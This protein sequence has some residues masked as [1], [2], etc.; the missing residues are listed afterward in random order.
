MALTQRL[1]RALRAHPRA[2][3]FV[4]A[5][6]P[7]TH[8]TEQH[9]QCWM[10]QLVNKAQRRVALA[11]DGH[12]DYPVRMQGKSESLV[13]SV[14]LVF[15]VRLVVSANIS[16][17]IVA[18]SAGC[19]PPCEE[20]TEVRSVREES[21]TEVGLHGVFAESTPGKSIAV[22]DNGTIL[23][24][25]EDG[26]WTVGVSGTSVTL[27]AVAG[28]GVDAVA[29]G[30]GGTIVQTSDAG[31]TW[32]VVASGTTTDLHAVAFGPSGSTVI[33]V[34]A[35]GA[36]HSHDNGKTW[37]ITKLPENIQPLRA[38]G[39]FNRASSTNVDF[40]AAGDN[41]EVLLSEDLGGNWTRL[42]VGTRADLR[43][44]GLSA[45]PGATGATFMVA[46]AAGIARKMLDEHGKSW[47]PH[48]LALTADIVHISSDYQWQLAVDGSVVLESEA[49]PPVT[50]VPTGSLEAIDGL[51]FEAYA[52][53]TSGTIVHL[54]VE[55]PKCRYIY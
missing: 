28:R 39:A 19:P 35:E 17:G 26:S 16:V 27:L 13:K 20:L 21:G 2:G 33:A 46:G 11:G 37:N 29:V 47:G 51:W 24:R 18:V 36:V 31:A 42:D 43:V 48:D 40:L 30:H 1:T 10:K 14:F 38:V 49:F 41:G 53:G 23:V 44:V 5:R 4:L 22:G 9:V 8:Y 45:A 52:V 12:W 55:S 50:A 34:G 32:Q 7:D 54:S 6:E 15:L 3:T 25:E